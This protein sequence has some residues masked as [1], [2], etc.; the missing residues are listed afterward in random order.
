MPHPQANRQPLRLSLDDGEPI[1]QGA[2]SLG[3]VPLQLGT[4]P[5]SHGLLRPLL[6]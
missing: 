4:N 3:S 1:L 6:G 2:R 5:D